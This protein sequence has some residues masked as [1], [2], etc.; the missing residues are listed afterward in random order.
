M[1]AITAK[2]FSKST[3]A[4]NSEAVFQIKVSNNQQMV[5]QINV[6]KNSEAVIQSE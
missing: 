3:L 2:W 1:L 4:K 5:F 6:S